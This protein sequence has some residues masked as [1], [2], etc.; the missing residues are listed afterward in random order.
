M[1]EDTGQ[2]RPV[3]VVTGATGAI[4]S[5]TARR[6]VAA[7]WQVALLARDRERVEDLAAEL[8]PGAVPFV[9]DLTVSSAVDAAFA[10]IVER[11]RPPQSLVHAV[12]STMLK[13][14][15]ALSDAEIEEVL[16]VNLLSAFYAMRAFV[17]TAPRG[18]PAS[19]LLFSSAATKIGLLNHEAIAAAKG[20]IEGLVTSAAA[21]Y[22]A[23]G[24]RVN[25]I[26]PG[27]VRSRMT[28]RLVQNEA[29]LRVSE[30]MHPLGRIGDAED[31]AA[32]AA[33][34]VTSEAGWITGQVIAVDGGLSG[35]KL[36]PRP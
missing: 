35:V 9:A 1:S 22:A 32:L 34:L 6:L 10:G 7:G 33:F 23:R 29:T 4:G 13:P 30:A 3:A 8:G 36:A 15:H 12:G 19:I 21:T 26:A 11:L 27:L 2:E 24:I 31:V 28:Q 25:A 18:Q 20:G 14:V 17:R 16:A 5:A